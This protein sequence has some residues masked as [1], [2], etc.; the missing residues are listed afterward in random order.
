M[1]RA[2][3][4]FS[5]SIATGDDSCVVSLSGELDMASAPELA[6]ALLSLPDPG[7]AEIVVDF[8]DLSFVDS[9]GIAVLIEAQHRLAEDGRRLSIHSARRHAMRVFEI[10]GL[11]DFL[12]VAPNEE[13]PST[14]RP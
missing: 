4:G 13:S 5:A 8:S 2:P 1:G 14:F 3:D 11:L 7:P 9:S 10:S 12:N 6:H